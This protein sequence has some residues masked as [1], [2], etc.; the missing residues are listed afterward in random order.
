MNM[1]NVLAFAKKVFR[2]IKLGDRYFEHTNVPV[3][4]LV[5]HDKLLDYLVEI[6]NKKGLRILE[7]G[8]REVTGPSKI[9]ERLFN[10][11]YVGFDF[12]PGDNVDVVGDAH[13]LSLYFDEKFDIIFSLA[14]FE[15]FAMPWVVAQEVNKLLKVGGFVLIETHFSYSSHERP[16]HFF[17]YSDMGLRALFPPAMG[18]KCLDAGMS[19]PIVGRFS[20]FA[21][22]YLRRK[23][24]TGLYCHS[25]FL[26]Q[27]I[28]AADDFS[29]EKLDLADVVGDSSYPLG[30][31]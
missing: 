21:V 18:I 3:P 11:D 28:S 23:P 9:R 26:G 6:G 30:N 17:Q 8:S 5:S 22:K 24:V 13:K 16:W 1:V 31:G 12:Y 10:A 14:C 29:W 20:S 15:H 19:N 2:F 25:E 4:N 7:I 27:K